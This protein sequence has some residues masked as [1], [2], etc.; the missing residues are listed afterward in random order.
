MD[1]KYADD[2]TTWRARILA[3]YNAKSPDFG[4]RREWDDYLEEVEDIIYSVVNKDGG[5]GKHIQKIKELEASGDAVIAA[6]QA[7]SAEDV[8]LVKEKLADEIAESDRLRLERVG[9]DEEITKVKKRL[10]K[11]KLELKL[12]DRDQMSAEM[13]QAKKV[14]VEAVVKSQASVVKAGT[15]GAKC[16]VFE[17]TGGLRS[18]SVVN[19]MGRAAV[20]TRV[21]SAGSVS[22]KSIEDHELCW[23]EAMGSLLL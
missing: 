14:G 9:E 2:D 6:R 23:S 3:V 13:V 4:T 22:K 12:G 20:A 8:R 17:P 19:S 11:E 16:H 1:D 10:K 5:A 7:R 21:K 18:R 15:D